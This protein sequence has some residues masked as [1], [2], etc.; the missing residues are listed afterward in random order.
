[1]PPL[2]DGNPEGARHG[3]RARQIGNFLVVHPLH[4]AKQVMLHMMGAF[5]NHDLGDL[6]Q[7]VA[8]D[9]PRVDDD[10]P[11]L[12]VFRDNPVN[13]KKRTFLYR[14]RKCSHDCGLE[15]VVKNLYSSSNLHFVVASLC[16]DSCV[17]L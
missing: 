9:R 13:Q 14:W 2:H 15:F 8:S 4:M 7:I 17:A 3:Y 5:M 6:P 16:R 10:R 11:G 1:M 12:C